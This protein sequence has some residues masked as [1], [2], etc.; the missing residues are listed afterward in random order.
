MLCV[1]GGEPE[2]KF[3]VKL[4]RYKDQAEQFVERFKDYGNVS[5]EIVDDVKEKARSL[6]DDNSV[7][8]EVLPYSSLEKE[9]Q[10]QYKKIIN[11][12]TGAKE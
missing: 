6:Y 8:F 9:D 1:L 4:L 10:S 3:H 11:L 7:T 2:K 5:F 12:I